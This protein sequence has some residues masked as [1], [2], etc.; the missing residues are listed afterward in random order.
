MIRGLM[1]FI[2]VSS[3]QLCWYRRRLFFYH[4][5]NVKWAST[6][7]RLMTLYQLYLRIS[8]LNIEI[9][10]VWGNVVNVVDTRLFT[11]F[12]LSFMDWV[13]IKSDWEKCDRIL[14]WMQVTVYIIFI[15][16]SWFGDEISLSK[17]KNIVRNTSDW[18]ICIY[19]ELI[20]D[21]INLINTFFRMQLI[22]SFA[23]KFN[24]I[25]LKMIG[26]HIFLSKFYR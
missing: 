9:K 13:E 11:Y 20:Y 1:L 5:I 16:K 10:S 8:I 18:I 7:I 17:C 24:S 2:R 6:S 19:K 14:L 22:I 12:C 4:P 3:P 21:K 15:W 25:K 26:Y 23:F